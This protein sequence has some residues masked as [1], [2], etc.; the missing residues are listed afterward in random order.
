CIRLSS[1]STSRWTPLPS[2]TVLLTRARKGLSPSSLTTY[3][4]HATRAKH[5]VTSHGPILL[6]ACIHWLLERKKRI[7][8]FFTSLAGPPLGAANLIGPGRGH[9]GGWNPA[10]MLFQPMAVMAK[11]NCPVRSDHSASHGVRSKG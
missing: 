10:E 1:D 8:P 3:R 2:L 6:C 4:S 5:C 9:G 7:S 11:E